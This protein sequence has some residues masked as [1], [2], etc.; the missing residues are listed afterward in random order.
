[1]PTITYRSEKLSEEE[2]PDYSESGVQMGIKLNSTDCLFT[3][4]WP[5]IAIENVCK[6]LSILHRT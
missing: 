2:K 6:E 5:M 1:M 4:F 3:I